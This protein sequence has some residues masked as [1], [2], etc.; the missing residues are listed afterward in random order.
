MG[1]IYVAIYH[2]KWFTVNEGPVYC[3]IVSSIHHNFSVI[4]CNCAC[5]TCTGN[6]R[7]IPRYQLVPNDGIPSHLVNSCVP[8]EQRGP[9][10]EISNRE[11][12]IYK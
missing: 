6:S 4:G 12:Y 1:I 9:A 10:L 8:T 7:T 2:I 11:E 5:N 3:A